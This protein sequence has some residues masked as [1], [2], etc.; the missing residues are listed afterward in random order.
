MKI[1]GEG[2]FEA[3]RDVFIFKKNTNEIHWYLWLYEIW[4]FARSS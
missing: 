2:L 3:K 4:S 1:T